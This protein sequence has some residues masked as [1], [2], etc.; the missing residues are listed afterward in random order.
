MNGSDAGQRLD[1][2]GSLGRPQFWLIVIVSIVFFG[3]SM[4][5]WVISGHDAHNNVRVL[6]LNAIVL[7]VA[8]LLIAFAI[9]RSAI[10]VENDM[11]VVNTGIGT[12][13]IALA[14][15]RAHGLRVVN[16]SEHTELKPLIRL[17]GT[18]L[19]GFAAGWF[20]LRNGDKAVCLLLDRDHVSW[21][22][23]DVDRLTL[24]LSLAKPEKLRAMLEASAT[25]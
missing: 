18:G 3:I 24:L 10:R 8:L 17:W 23:S 2:N 1:L 7:V 22:R 21:L 14:N 5:W 15:L 11:L 6:A 16:L 20:K 12:K 9:G 4:A 19:P 25:H 13:R